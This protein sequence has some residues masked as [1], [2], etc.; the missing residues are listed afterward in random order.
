MS[1][2]VG[3]PVWFCTSVGGGV[4]GEGQTAAWR[5]LGIDA[6]LHHSVDVKTYWQS[7]T[8]LFARLKLRWAMYASYPVKLRSEILSSKTPEIF[9]AVTN[10]FFLPALA[11][12][13]GRRSG[14]QVIQ[15]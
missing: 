12:R 10:P 6:R 1:V 14:A 11:A 15:L 9:V 2:S 7:K 13:S 4:F 8:A 5:S 3:A